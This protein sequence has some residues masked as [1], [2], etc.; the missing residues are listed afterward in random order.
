MNADKIRPVGQQALLG[1]KGK[2]EKKKK[3]KASASDEKPKAKHFFLTL[4]LLKGSAQFTEQMPGLT[5]SKLTCQRSKQTVSLCWFSPLFVCFCFVFTAEPQRRR[6]L[7][8]Q[9]KVVGII[10]LI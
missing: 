9:L 5:L 8:F 2:K 6:L 7:E 1:E 4:Q 3:R 10:G